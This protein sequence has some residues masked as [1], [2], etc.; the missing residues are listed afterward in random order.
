MAKFKVARFGRILGVI[1]AIYAICIALWK[2]FTLPPGD[3]ISLTSF[4][5]A[6]GVLAALIELP[7]CFVCCK[8]CKF[9]AS[10]LRVVTGY[11]IVRGILYV[12]AFAAASVNAL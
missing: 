1:Y 6:A 9:V 5:F 8:P 7:G 10:I 12:G 4:S 2:A 3:A 11:W